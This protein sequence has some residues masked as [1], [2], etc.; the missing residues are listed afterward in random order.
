[1]GNYASRNNDFGNALKDTTSV[2][3]R[4]LAHFRRVDFPKSMLVQGLLRTI[5]T[6]WEGNHL[7]FCSCHV[8]F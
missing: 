3:I 8:F 7:V 4:N 5:G 6:H 1:M 2:I